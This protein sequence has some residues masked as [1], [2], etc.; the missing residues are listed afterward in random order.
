MREVTVVCGLLLLAA[1]G[2][3]ES[4]GQGRSDGPATTLTI[5]VVADEDAEPTTMTLTCDPVG[6]DHPR[7]RAACDALATAGPDVFE[8][9]PVDQACTMIYGGPQQATIVG[10]LDGED[11]DA[12]FSRENGCEMARWDA[13]GTE[14]FDLPLQ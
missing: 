3:Q 10:T 4:G 9:V 1:C 13:L 7:A 5:E 12:S 11:V 6:G 2:Q 14:V 8:P